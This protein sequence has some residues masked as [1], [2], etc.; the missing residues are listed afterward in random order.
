MKLKYVAKVLIRVRLKTFN[1]LFMHL[2][3][4]LWAKIMNAYL[5]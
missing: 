5:A 3:T 1:K 4:N 2:H